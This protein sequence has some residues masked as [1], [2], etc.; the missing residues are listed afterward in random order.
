MASKS[1]T[2]TKGHI[3]QINVEELTT[4]MLDVLPLRLLPV[5]REIIVICLNA[6]ELLNP[7]SVRA[8]LTGFQDDLSPEERKHVPSYIKIRGILER[9]ESMNLLDTR[10]GEG[11]TSKAL[12]VVNPHFY[13]LW[14]KRKKEIATEAI[15]KKVDPVA[16]YPHLILEFYG[17]VF[18]LEDMNM[19]RDMGGIF[20]RRK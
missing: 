3:E 2:I 13:R 9:L 14:L 12:W 8:H 10:S 17:I 18:Y 19:K 4:E 5:E 16:L 15:N 6:A 20:N 7:Y 1:R 11:T